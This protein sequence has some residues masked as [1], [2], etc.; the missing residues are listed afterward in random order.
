MEMAFGSGEQ[1]VST[2]VD[3]LGEIVAQ[4]GNL[5]QAPVEGLTGL[6]GQISTAI[7][8]VLCPRQPMQSLGVGFGR[9]AQGR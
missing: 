4:T 5:V 3:G 1:Q 6:P 8:E 7:I 9:M 2:A